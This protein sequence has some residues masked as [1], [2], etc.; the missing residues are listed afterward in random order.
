MS[1]ADTIMTVE[2]ERGALALSAFKIKALQQVDATSTQITYA[3]GD[4]DLAPEK[5]AVVRQSFEELRAE[6]MRALCAWDGE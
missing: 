4:S 5:V 1:Y 2:T 3:S 6:W